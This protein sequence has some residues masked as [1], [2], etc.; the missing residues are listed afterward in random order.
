MTRNQLGTI[1]LVDRSVRG[2][3]H[4]YPDIE[5]PEAEAETEQRLVQRSNKGSE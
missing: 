5:I 1:K 2:L 4:A 3:R